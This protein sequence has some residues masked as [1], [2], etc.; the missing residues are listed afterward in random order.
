MVKKRDACTWVAQQDRLL[1]P[2]SLARLI[3][4]R[5]M[6]FT[7][8]LMIMA[9]GH[10]SYKLWQ[11]MVTYKFNLAPSVCRHQDMRASMEHWLCWPLS[12]IFCSTFFRNSSALHQ[13][14]HFQFFS[15]TYYSFVPKTGVCAFVLHSAAPPPPGIKSRLF[16]LRISIC[17]WNLDSSNSPD[18]SSFDLL[19]S[20]TERLL[21]RNP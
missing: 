11:S 2:D 5:P 10:P 21:I 9:I 6:S 20:G 13:I 1:S 14:S 7:S 16:Q 17:G 3:Y 19:S 8:S 4:W 18:S 12:S 15:Y